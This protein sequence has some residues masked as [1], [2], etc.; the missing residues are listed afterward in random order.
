MHGKGSVKVEGGK[1]VRVEATY[2]DVFEDVSITGDFF[3][4]P[5]EA[6]EEIESA[7]EGKNVDEDDQSLINAIEEVE[8]DFIGF[9]P[10]HVVQAL[11]EVV[12]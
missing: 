6:L 5:P 7:I 1:L 2:D 12:A 11:R 3:L 8:A 4:E 9:R 10:K